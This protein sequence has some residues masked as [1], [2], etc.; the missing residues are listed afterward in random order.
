MRYF[1][2][3][4]LYLSIILVSLVGYLLFGKF[5]FESRINSNLSDSLVHI[6]YKFNM[7]DRLDGVSFIN[8]LFGSGYNNLL[9][10]DADFGSMIYYYGILLAPF[11]LISIYNK[12]K[13]IIGGFNTLLFYM[14]IF[15]GTILTNTRM[16]AVSGAIFCILSTLRMRR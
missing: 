3:I 11:L 9:F 10:F 5:S 1:K 13:I 16:V 6:L 14:L 15:Y 4:Y 2:S 12:L 7:L 8:L